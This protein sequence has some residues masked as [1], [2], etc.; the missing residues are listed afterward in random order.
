MGSSPSNDQPCE[1]HERWKC[2]DFKML[3]IDTTD[4]KILCELRE[5]ARMSNSEIAKKLNVT[6]A[7]VRRRIKNLIEKGI[8]MRF[9]IHIDYRLIENTVKAYVHIK[10][11]TDKLDL[12]VRHLVNHDRVVAVYRVTGEYDILVVA[13]FVGM[14]ELQE[15]IDTFLKT[16]GIKETDTQIVMSAHKGVPWTG[17]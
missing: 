2:L 17:I 16:D 8:I 5:N 4:I 11:V 10:T 12:V 1:L 7:T 9:S 6:E 15:F 13:L 3:P 14:T